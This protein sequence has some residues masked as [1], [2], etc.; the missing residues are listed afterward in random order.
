MVKPL[1]KLDG[2]DILGGSLSPSAG[3]SP[4]RFLIGAYHRAW[5]L[6]LNTHGV[7]V[8]LWYPIP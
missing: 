8:M 2:D 7:L 4:D 5:Q 3:A 1:L 6:L